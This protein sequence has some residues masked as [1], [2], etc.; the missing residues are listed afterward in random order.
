M[1]AIIGGGPAGIAL[2]A[3]LDHHCIAYTLVEARQIGETWRRVPPD[4]TVLSP[5][6]TNV[7]DLRGLTEGLPLS[8]LPAGRYVAHLERVAAG[9]RGTILTNTRALN[10]EAAGH[11]RWMISLLRESE[12]ITERLEAHA[13]V[14]CTGYFDRPAGPRPSFDSDGTIPLRHSAEID[15]FELLNRLGDPSKP[16][17]IVGKRVTAGQFLL[18][19]TAA[20]RMVELSSPSAVEFRR[21]GVLAWCRE[22]LYYGW[23]E[24]QL[25]GNPN[26]KRDSYPP[27]EGGECRRLIESGAVTIQPAVAAIQ[28]G[29]VHFCNG[30]SAEYGA[31]LLATGYLPQLALLESLQPNVMQQGKNLP[32]RLA[33]GYELIEHPGIFLLGYDNL[34]NHRSRYLRGIRSDARELAG[35]ISARANP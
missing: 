1:I 30:N 11:G 17:L 15:R 19:L 27:M 21:H 5:W 34:R 12:M 25:F 13:V 20:G 2:A 10:L 28:K 29:R 31:V 16:V 6:C 33:P 7:L 18:Q 22:M 26:L 4:L 3:A 24:L 32:P 14:L 8:K 9:L 23:E 35:L